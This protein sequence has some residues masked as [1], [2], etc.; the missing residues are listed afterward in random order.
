M[1]RLTSTG[2]SGWKSA[3]KSQILSNLNERLD[4]VRLTIGPAVTIQILCRFLLQRMGS[5]LRFTFFVAELVY[6]AVSID[7]RTPN[8]DFLI[9]GIL[10]NAVT[11]RSNKNW[12][13]WLISESPWAS[14]Q[15]TSHCTS[16][17]Y[18]RC[19][20]SNSHGIESAACHRLDTRQPWFGSS[21]QFWHFRLHLEEGYSCWS[22][23]E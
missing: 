20:W 16:L 22:P 14:C 18:R 23:Q 17:I 12:C 3:W 4:T 1:P 19:P 9:L 7:Q 6:A 11:S 13:N 21:L 5:F 10:R 2:S 15:S 8:G